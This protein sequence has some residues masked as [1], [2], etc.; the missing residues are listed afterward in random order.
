[1]KRLNA[2]CAA[3]LLVLLA[4]PGMFAL[5]DLG[6][7]MKQ[8][9]DHR[10]DDFASLRKDPHGSGD[11]TAYASSVILPGAMQC[12]IAQT[13]KPHYSNE[14]D[15]LETK[16]RGTLT[17]KYRQMVKALREVSPASWTSW[18]GHPGKPMG[19]STYVGPDRLHPAAAVHWVLEGM[20]LDWYDLSVTFYGEGYTLAEPK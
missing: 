17:A 4:G 5:D 8:I 14:C 6:A 18:T 10:G 2:F 20:N 15:V 9:L 19:E 16:N 7:S 1:M 11:E 12:Y 13:A 3:L